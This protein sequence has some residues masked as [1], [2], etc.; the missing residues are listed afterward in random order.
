M[1]NKGPINN[2]INIVL[3]NDKISNND[4]EEDGIFFNNILNSNMQSN[5]NK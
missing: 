5:E 4:E 2:I 1:S 3:K